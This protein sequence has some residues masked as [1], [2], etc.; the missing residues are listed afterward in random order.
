MPARGRAPKPAGQRVGR[1]PPQ[2][3]EWVLLPDVPYDG[4][5]PVVS[6]PDWPPNTQAW[7][8][9]VSTQP[10][11]VLWSAAEWEFAL[12]TAHVHAVA[13]V[14]PP[15]EV[16]ARYLPELRQREAKLGM[17]K[18]DR[19]GLRIRYVSADVN[20]DSAD[21]VPIRTIGLSSPPPPTG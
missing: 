13:F 18:V 17:T 19:M 12:D 14:D 16:V 11:C 6:D 9:A 21:V 7:W 15:R 4:P 2:L 10:H 20:A 5:V 3:G 1:H 8:A